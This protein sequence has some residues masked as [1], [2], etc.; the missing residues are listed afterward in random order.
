[1]SL[2]LSNRNWDQ[3]TREYHGSAPLEHAI[4]DDF[5]APTY[6]DDV[7][8]F[9]IN[10]GGWRQKNWQV[11]QLF[12]KRPPLPHL[13]D[14]IREIR[15]SLSAILQGTELVAHW[16][17]LCH[18]NEG[19]H[20]HA[21][22]ARVAVN[23]WL[24]PDRYNRNNRGGMTLHDLKRN[25]TMAVHEFNAMPWAGQIL[26]AASP[27]RSIPI[28]YREN[29]AVVFDAAIF[30]A[31]DEIEF[32]SSGMETLRLSLTFAFDDPDEYA[33]RMRQYKQPD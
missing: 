15:A 22:N 12:N 33:A 28:D 17:V 8:S 23:M 21:D 9:L 26:E 4:L 24:T 16:A 2:Y 11:G 20:V 13:D 6:L 3:V 7:R 10:D 19:L 29:R 18:Q 5:L 27:T 32:D 30:H 1:M 31:S 14:L 25:N